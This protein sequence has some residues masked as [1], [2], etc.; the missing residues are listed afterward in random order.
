[1]VTDYY[2]IRSEKE[3]HRL[4]VDD[5]KYIQVEGNYATLHYKERQFTL[6][7]SLK[8]MEE[9]LPR[10]QFIRV[11]RNT[12]VNVGHI[13]KVDTI[14]NKVYLSDHALPLGNHFKDDLL[15][16]FTLLN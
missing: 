14:S 8:K 7:L 15:K 10:K 12:I 4:L 3:Y 11:H 6:K 9:A 1:M 2:L 5:I 16:K 13:S